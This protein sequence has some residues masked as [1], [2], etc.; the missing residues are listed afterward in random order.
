[1]ETN[2]ANWFTMFAC[3]ASRSFDGWYWS[4]S[5]RTRARKYG[6]RWTY[7]ATSHVPTR[8]SVFYQVRNG[9]I[10]KISEPI[11]PPSR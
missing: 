3:T 11:D 6:S 8:K 9:K 4:W 5:W 7:S 10:D 1:M 2:L